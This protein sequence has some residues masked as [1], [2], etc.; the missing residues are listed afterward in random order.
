MATRSR[1][2]R[3]PWSRADRKSTRLNSSHLV[4]SYAVFCLKKK[5]HSS[6][7]VQ[8]LHRTSLHLYTLHLHLDHGLLSYRERNDRA[9][10]CHLTLFHHI[11]CTLVR[12]SL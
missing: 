12:L 3:F 11:T 1:S 10:P 6:R 8:S 9:P 7:P 5:I 4:I 2:S